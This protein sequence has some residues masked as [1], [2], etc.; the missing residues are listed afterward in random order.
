MEYLRNVSKSLVCIENRKFSHHRRICRKSW[1]PKSSGRLHSTVYVHGNTFTMR[2]FISYTLLYGTCA[3]WLFTT[4]YISFSLTYYILC[5]V[6]LKVTKSVH[7]MSLQLILPQCMLLFF[8]LEIRIVCMSIFFFFFLFNICFVHSRRLM[9]TLENQTNEM[10][11]MENQMVASISISI[12]FV[13]V[14]EKN[15]S[16][17]YIDNVQRQK[18]LFFK[19]KS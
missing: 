3:H 18:V 9:F 11:W 17:R 12:F 6:A 8:D 10:K 14:C 19:K 7:I 4:V 15:S 1:K 16:T 13:C 5:F 2:T